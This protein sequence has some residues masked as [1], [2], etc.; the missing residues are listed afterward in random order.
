MPSSS[1]ILIGSVQAAVVV[2]SQLDRERAGNLAGDLH[3][4]TH[5]VLPC[6]VALQLANEL[7]Y[8]SDFVSSCLMRRK[9]DLMRLN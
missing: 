5:R 4:R 2:V 6:P 9:A 3:E 1:P 8:T 7:H